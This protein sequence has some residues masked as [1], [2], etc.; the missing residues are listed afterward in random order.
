MFERISEPA[1]SDVDLLRLF[2]NA[3]EYADVYVLARKRQR[4]CDGMGELAM[5]REE[6]RDA[7]DILVR[8]CKQKEYLSQDVHY[9][10]DSIADELSER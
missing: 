7:V 9:D 5:V 8:Y 1:K 10:I 2:E 4:G 3:R 6:F